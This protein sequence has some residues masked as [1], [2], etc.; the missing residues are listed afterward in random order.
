VP[1]GVKRAP[2]QHSSRRERNR[3]LASHIELVCANVGFWHFR[4]FWTAR[5]MSAFVGKA[6]ISDPCSNVCLRPK[7]DISK[8]AATKAHLARVTS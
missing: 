7:A 6:D 8:Y 2:H 1:A 4:T 5:R 3:G